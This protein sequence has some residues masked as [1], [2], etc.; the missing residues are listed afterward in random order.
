MLS[1]EKVHLFISLTKVLSLK[2]IF[3]LVGFCIYNYQF[4][5]F[6]E[7]K[8]KSVLKKASV[9]YLNTVLIAKSFDQVRF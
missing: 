3:H 1:R 8:I 4:I 5:N 6:F 9:N 7:A 2:W